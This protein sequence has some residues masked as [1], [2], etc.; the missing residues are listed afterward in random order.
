M[1][2]LNFPSLAGGEIAP[3]FYGRTDQESYFVSAKSL[4]NTIASQTGPGIGRGGT[5]FI[6]TT[7]DNGKAL[8]IPFQFNEEQAYIAEFGDQ[9]IRI[10]RNHGLV[11]EDAI[12]VASISKANPA[13][14][15]A[16]HDLINGRT[17]RL[18]GAA[19]SMVELPDGF[20][21]VQSVLG[22]AKN[23]TDADRS[24]PVKITLDGGHG[25]VGGESVFVEAITGMTELNDRTFEL[26][27]VTDKILSI[28]AISQANPAVVT[29]SGNHGLV[30]GET[31]LI[32]G[33]EGMTQVNNQRYVIS[34][35]FGSALTINAITKA[36]PGVVTTTTNHGLAH[37]AQVRITSVSG[38][39]EVNNQDFTAGRSLQSAKTITQLYGFANDPVRLT[40]ASHG[41]STGD[42]V[43]ISA[44][45]YATQLLGRQFTITVTGTDYFELNGTTVGGVSTGPSFFPPF[46]S[47]GGTVARVDKNKFI[48]TGVDTTGYTTYTSGGS[49]SPYVLNQFELDSTDSTG[50]GAYTEGGTASR[51]SVND[52][53]LA[54]EN[55]IRHTA[56]ASGGT[57]KVVDKTQ[58]AL[59][60]L[61][62]TPINSSAF[63]DYTSGATIEAIHEIP[64][65]YAAADLFDADG[66]PLIQYAQSADFL[67]LAHP[68]YPPQQLTRS[69]HAN[70]MCS[71]FINEEGPFLD[72]NL[73]D[74]RIVTEAPNGLGIG[75]AVTLT[76]TEPLWSDGHV[77]ALWQL[78]LRDDATA[79]QWVT[80]TAFTVGQE[81]ISGNLFY[82]CTDAGTSGTEAPTH[83]IGE[84]YD[85]ADSSA[86][87]KWLYI[88]NGRGIVVITGY[89]SPTEVSATIVSELPA[90]V[91][92]STPRWNEGAWSYAQGFPRAVAIHEGR[93]VWG[94]MAQEPLG[95]DFS[96]TE[97]LFFYNPIEL[98]GTV[99]R[100]SAFR[101]VL[102]GDN[103]IRWMRSTEKG[104]IV[105][106]LAG[107]WVVGTEGV[108]QGFG[109]DTAVARQFSANGA[110]AI[111]PV[112]NGDS[113]LYPQRARKRLRDITFSIDQQKLVTSDRN[114]R[115]DHIALSG[116]IA[117]AY[118]EEP[119]RVTW[120]LLADGTLAGLT[121]N[122]EP[123]AQVSA[124]HHH[125]IGGSFGDGAAVVE[126]IATI[127]GPDETTDDLY[128]VVKRTIN[129]ETV[130]YVEYM[131]KP[132]DYGEDIEDGTYMDSCLVYDGAPITNVTGLDHLEG[133][134]VDV[135]A[136]GVWLQ[137]EVE[138]GSFTLDDAASRIAVGLYVPRWIETVYLESAPG[139]TLQT[140]A[141]TKRVR[142]VQI[143]VIESAKAWCGTS[144]DDM[145]QMIFD[146]FYEGD[147]PRRY[148]G[149]VEE[150]IS[151]DYGRRKFVRI[152]QRE[153]YPFFVASITARFE[154]SN[155]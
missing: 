34:P 148:T 7:K 129:G 23:I 141:Q 109:P 127:P 19:D 138:N 6:A 132:L 57:V 69:G 107:E 104:L 102:D 103:P 89:M 41:Y 71:E 17:V 143:E 32:E 27:P 22:S 75:A 152:E 79:V 106:T 82:R 110:A 84:A 94:G 4:R 24:S 93:L 128:M 135:L 66:I 14:V 145:D 5:M 25:L 29:V 146:E 76:A 105:G 154:V 30:D 117:T 78:R 87:C 85:G 53:Y 45:D 54:G 43:Y 139:D 73:G 1:P 40:V 36:N 65:P 133:E 151:D 72:E 149:F 26:V 136:D 96:N 15:T 122:R 99:V 59:A 90:G 64:S 88:H 113:L 9:Y 144:E 38:M 37:G 8:L 115:A 60:D 63:T 95:M 92:V 150:T 101:R 121:Y 130:R 67:F 83:D 3:A 50:Y 134:T 2:D 123:G 74:T 62:G 124:W 12:S 44:I 153:P 49:A 142:A 119:H 61:D 31:V 116:I 111:Q 10:Y 137:K 13:I 39:T 98:D 52:F 70:W 126:S 140:K 100:S 46:Y 112:R 114:L 16:A 47:E 42:F 35:K 55:G 108:T 97:S 11:L 58:F 68:S 28:T 125:V 81:V 18:L 80:G 51:V 77:G 147:A 131:T 120:N 86:N 20:Y 155:D 21:K 33:V 118:A 48:L 91:T 56:Y